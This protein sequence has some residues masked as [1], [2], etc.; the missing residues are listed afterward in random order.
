MKT[1][2]LVLALLAATSL[3]YAQTN[4]PL[5]DGAVPVWTHRYWQCVQ[6]EWQLVVEE[7]YQCPPDN[8]FQKLVYYGIPQWPCDEP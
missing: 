1:L 3:S 5:C 4:Q 6:D 2:A 8:R 7:Y